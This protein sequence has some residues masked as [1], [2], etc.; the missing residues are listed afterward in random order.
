MNNLEKQILDMLDNG[1]S[2]D[3]IEEHLSETPKKLEPVMKDYN[4][5]YY[6]YCCQE[7]ILQEEGNCCGE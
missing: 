1:Y 4:M 5:Y 3:E 6:Y 2:I 7:M